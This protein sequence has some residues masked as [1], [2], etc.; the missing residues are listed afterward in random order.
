MSVEQCN[1]CVVVLKGFYLS[2]WYLSNLYDVFI[3]I[4]INYYFFTFCLYFV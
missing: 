2:I 3:I 4:I 1:C